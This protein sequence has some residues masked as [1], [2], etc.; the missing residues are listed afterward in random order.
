MQ[1]GVI[2][3]LVELGDRYAKLEVAPGMKIEVL[4]SGLLGK[5]SGEAA[6]A[7]EKKK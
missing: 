2:G 7:A 1:S 6:T 3:K 4:K 5:D